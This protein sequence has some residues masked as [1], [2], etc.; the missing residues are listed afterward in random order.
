MKTVA[1]IALAAATGFASADV[2]FDADFSGT[3]GYD[4]S[5]S[6]P[7]AAGPSSIAVNNFFL[8]YNETPATDSGDNY[9]RVS[10]GE[11]QLRDFGGPAGL[12]SGSLDVSNFDEV[13]FTLSGETAG[14]QVFNN[15]GTTTGGPEFFAGFYSLDGGSDVEVARTINDGDLSFSITIDV[16]GASTLEVG[17]LSSVNGSGDGFDV[18]AITVSGD[19]VPTP[20]SAALLG[21]GGLIATRRRRA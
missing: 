12:T 14:S 13:T 3:G 19:P 20:A 6:N 8:F 11:L 15:Q 17:L 1:M 18:S 4:H 16:S 7:P 10:G 5:T 2:I 9:F 21:L